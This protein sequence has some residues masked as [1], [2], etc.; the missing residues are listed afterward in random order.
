MIGRSIRPFRR[1]LAAVAV[2]AVAVSAAGCGVAAPAVP[3]AAGAAASPAEEQPTAKSPA[4][5]PVQIT[6]KPVESNAGPVPPP[7]G[8]PATAWSA[9]LRFA[10]LREDAGRPLAEATAEPDCSLPGPGCTWPHGT[11]TV[12][13]SAASGTRALRTEVFTRWKAGGRAQLGWPTSSEYRFGGDYRTDFQR[14]SLMYVPRLGRVM[15]YD[16]EV[17][18]SAVVIGDSQSGKD[19]W[20]G[21]GLTSLGYAPVI[22]GAG[23]TGYTRG[24]GTVDS[25]PE[26]LEEEEWLLPW[27]KPALV[28]LQG[29][30][31][32]AYGASNQAIRHNAIQLIREVRRTYP[33]ARIVVVGVIGT[34]S[35]RR[36][37]I[38]NLMGQVAAE[39]GLDFLSLRDWWSRYSL[40]SKLDDGVHLG[41]AGHDIAA[42]IFARELKG[43]LD[44]PRP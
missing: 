13:W 34:G 3:P 18:E 38:D 5:E 12:V 33:E 28:I 20:V 7:A 21:R 40:S 27:G 15:A 22:L 32:D 25:Y 24:N 26:A 35:G 10:E 14:G 29:G 4:R 42:P 16:S 41:K 30:G 9:M 17:D 8:V 11:E 2:L 31:N 43:I 1:A 19:T 44:Q 6:A 36:G 37:E 23:G 39:Q